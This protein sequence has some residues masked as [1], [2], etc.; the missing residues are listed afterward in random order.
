MPTANKLT[1]AL[2][3][4]LKPGPTLRK[5]ADGLGLALVVTPKG[6]KVWRLFYRVHGRPQTMSLGRYPDIGLAEARRKR[7]EA[8]EVLRSGGDPMQPRREARP[9]LTLKEAAQ[10]YWAGRGDVTDGYRGN[11]IRALEMH[12]YGRLGGRPVATLTREDFME[13]LKPMDAAGRFVYVRKVRMW[14]GQVMDWCVERGD[15]PINPLRLIDSRKAFGRRQVQS[16]AAVDLRE[17]GPLLR[18]VA[19]EGELQSVLALR[20]LALTWVRTNELRMMC[21]SEI[22]GD[23]WRIPAGKMKR[24]RDHLVP[25]PRQA[26]ELLPVLRARS[27]ASPYVFPADHRPDRPMS[28]NAVLYLLARIGYRGRMTGHGWRSVA[29]TWANEAGWPPDAIE[30]QLAHA[31]ADRTRA[32]YNRAEFIDQRG[33]MLQAFADWLDAQAGGN[34]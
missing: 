5:H 6:A 7:D 25:L 30:R 1:D 14:L 29:S 11:A 9:S 4:G 32:V 16:F 19:M 12:A 24:R 10:A 18:R 8:R 27:G 26:V 34:R 31:P 3:R 23:M 2:V 17:V 33:A 15:A 28:E 13:V 20:M 22:D 21:W